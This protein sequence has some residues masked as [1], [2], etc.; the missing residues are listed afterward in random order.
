ME[1]YPK[2]AGESPGDLFDA[3]ETD[4][5]LAL[6]ILKLTEEE[7][8]EMRRA[9]P[10]ARSLL[11]RTLALGAAG[12]GLHGRLTPSKSLAQPLSAIATL[13]DETTPS[14]PF[15]PGDRV[16]LRPSG[17]ADSMDVLLSGRTA[18]VRR[19]ERN[20]ENR[21]HVAVTVDDDPGTTSE[22]AATSGTASSSRSTTWN[23][24]LP[25]GICEISLARPYALAASIALAMN[26]SVHSGHRASP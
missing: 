12:L 22:K 8:E 14:R 16:R 25:R 11:S 3:T 20:L 10:R 7:K 18:T 5:I 6:R 1:D 24:S 23:P 17:R 19:V 9:D 13:D 15:A 4:E 2:V 26:R 21:I